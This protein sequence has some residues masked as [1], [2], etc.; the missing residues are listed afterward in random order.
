MKGILCLERGLTI[1]ATLLKTWWPGTELNRRRQAS[2]VLSLCCVLNNLSDFRWP[3][4]YL[5]SRERHENRGWKSWVQ[6]VIAKAT[7]AMGPELSQLHSRR[8]NAQGRSWPCNDCIPELL[9]GT[10]RVNSAFL[11]LSR[12][13]GHLACIPAAH[14]P[15]QQAAVLVE[16]NYVT[17]PLSTG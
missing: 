11:E 9:S 14:R 3:P 5:R 12:Q 2:S 8:V 16:L 10:K 6:T 13:C 15:F 4:K 1:V 17:Q 7:R